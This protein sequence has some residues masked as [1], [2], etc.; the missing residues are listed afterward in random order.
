[1][2]RF[3][4]ILLVALLGACA[5]EPVRPFGDLNGPVAVAAHVPSRQLL[6]ASQNSDELRVFDLRSEEFL[7]SPAVSFPLSVP[8]VRTPRLL[9]AG[10]RFVFVVSGADGSVGFVDTEVPPGAFGPRSVDDAEGRPIVVP[11]GISPTTAVALTSPHGYADEGQLGDFFLISGLLPDGSGGQLLAIRPP[12]EG[13]GPELLTTL[14]LP[15]VLPAGMALEEG[16]SPLEG[17]P[18]CRSYAIAD[19]G[20]MPGILIGRVEVSPAGDLS[21]AEPEQKIEVRVE[22]TLADGSREERLAPVRAVEFA[23]VRFDVQLPTA[24]AADPCAP[25]SGRIFAI[26]DTSYCAGAA[27][28]PNLVAIDLPS[29]EIARD[30]LLGE[31]AVYQLPAAPIGLLSIPG[32]ITV[33]QARADFLDV[34]VQPPAIRSGEAGRLASLLLV[35]STDGGITFVSGGLGTRLLGPDSGRRTASDPVFLLDGADAVPGLDR[36]VTRTDRRGTI[37]PSVE[38][39]PDAQPRREDW[40]AGFEIPLP[41]LG[42]L[43]GA[44]ALEGDRFLLPANSDR[45]F[46][47]PIPV[48]ASEEVE[49][50]DRLVPLGTAEDCDGFPIVAVEEGG[51]ALRVRTDAPGFVNPDE[52][53]ETGVSFAVLPP[54]ARPWTLEGSTTGFVGRA[55]AVGASAVHFGSRLLFVFR[56]PAEALER[57]ATFQWS[58]TPGFSF[59]RVSRSS[60]TLP[61]SMV[62]FPQGSSFRVAV[63]YSGA[64]AIT[65]FNPAAPPLEGRR[66]ID[67]FR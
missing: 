56:P 1:M 58:T 66:S 34:E 48:L 22:V 11:T 9:G 27:T 39:P 25:R 21:F 45:N 40:T 41:G 31:P 15:G 43:G 44:D 30:A 6:V 33:D 24:V 65:V 18:D 64:D 60:L 57:G 29:G 53:F 63:A 26:L 19:Q 35:S 37:L 23:P 28:C 61:A 46:E 10:E 47:S 4:P 20:R 51:R 52:C 3:V 7:A 14:D 2:R 5:E 32:P 12:F 8:T 67:I 42:S 16:F 55:P 13:A 36:P 17:I 62:R 49:E 59:Y 50:A 54:R 38:F